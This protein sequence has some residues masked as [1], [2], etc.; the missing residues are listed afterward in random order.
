MVSTFN[1]LRSVI[2]PLRTVQHSCMF[3]LIATSKNLC[4]QL[5]YVCVCVLLCVTPGLLGSLF[6]FLQFLT[7]PLLGA[8]SDIYGRKR[9]LILCMVREKEEKRGDRN[10]EEVA[11]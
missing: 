7:S 8:T 9:V 1:D 11:H 3:K 5:Q 6:S 4:V 2:C 10:M